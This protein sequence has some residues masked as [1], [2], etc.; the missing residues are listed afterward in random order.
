M[1]IDYDN[2]GGLQWDMNQEGIGVQ[3]MMANVNL[4]FKF[5]GGQDIEKPIERLQNAVTANYYA[6]ASIYSRHADNSEGYY[7]AIG[8]K[9]KNR[10]TGKYETKYWIEKEQ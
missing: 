4:N 8:T 1:S 10:S 9:V 2:G 3:P 5:I 6:N 7:D